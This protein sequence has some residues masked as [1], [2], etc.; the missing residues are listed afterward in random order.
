MKPGIL[1]LIIGGSLL[2]VGLGVG[3][4]SAYTVTTQVLEGSTLINSTPLD[5]NLS[6]GAVTKDLPAGQ[7]LLLSLS[8]TPSDVPLQAKISGPDG[9]TLA[10][11]NITRTPFTSTTTTKVSGDHT[12]EVKNVGSS[13]TTISGGLLTAPVSPQGGGVAVTDNKSSS[14]FQSLVAYGIGILVGILLIIAGI[15]LLIIGGVKY[16]KGR[17]SAPVGSSTSNVQ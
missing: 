11:Y 8:S 17:K 14:S 4:V 5:P 12:V 3:A 10:F 1:L 15:V 7:Q 9:S 6:Y 13:S 16:M 2:G